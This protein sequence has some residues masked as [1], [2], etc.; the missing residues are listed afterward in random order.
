[1][2]VQTG[3]DPV[4]KILPHDGFL[5]VEMNVDSGEEAAGGFARPADT[6]PE[7]RGRTAG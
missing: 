6:D 7:P 5:F 4:S 2:S 3:A 1:M